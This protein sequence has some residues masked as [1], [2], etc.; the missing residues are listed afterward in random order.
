MALTVAI[1]AFATFTKP[2]TAHAASLPNPPNNLCIEDSGGCVPPVAGS[3]HGVKW[4]PGHYVLTPGYMTTTSLGYTSSTISA[5]ASEPNIVGVVHRIYWAALEPTRGNYDF[6]KLDA[7]LALCQANGKRLIIDVWDRT[8]GGG[9]SAE[10]Y[11]PAYLATEPGGEGGWFARE[12][13]GV[14]A[15]IWLPAIMD[16][17][18]A[19]ARA[20]AAH[21]TGGYTLDTHPYVEGFTF[22]EESAAD[23]N[24]GDPASYSRSAL[25]TQLNRL[26]AALPLAWPHSNVFGGANFLSGEM[27]AMV[28]SAVANRAGIA[29]PD[30][31]P[32]KPT[33]AQRVFPGQ[34]EAGGTGI[35]Y[36]GKVPA[37]FMVQRAEIGGT[38]GNFT[39][40]Q[41]Y[42]VSLTYGTTHLPWLMKPSDATTT[43]WPNEILPF[44]RAGGHPLNTTCPTRYTSCNT[45]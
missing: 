8:Y 22:T 3:S 15:R 35:D 20:L 23:I 45:N 7:L 40:Q 36:R 6:S 13:G 21:V 25:A 5:L 33:A 31:I 14:M 19:L 43:D 29:G 41:I 26:A 27:D 1:A 39:P 44:V 28:G 32:G 42:D 9:S 34:T 37:L 38:K 30:T 24:N 2:P 10:G 11:L 16:R 18:I 4:H 12:R 17:E